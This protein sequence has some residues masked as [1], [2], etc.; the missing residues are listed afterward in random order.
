MNTFRNVTIDH[1]GK[2]MFV[3][4]NTFDPAGTEF[5]YYDNAVLP[6]TNAYFAS[7]KSLV[8]CGSITGDSTIKSAIADIIRD[9][10]KDV[11][12]DIVQS[13]A[14]SK[15]NFF[16]FQGTAIWAIKEVTSGSKTF[17]IVNGEAICLGPTKPSNIVRLTSAIESITIHVIFNGHTG[18]AYSFD[19]GENWIYLSLDK[20]SHPLFKLDMRVNLDHKP[21]ANLVPYIN[22]R[23][24][25][26]GYGMTP[27]YITPDI[28]KHSYTVA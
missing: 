2:L 5:I 27:Y 10:S 14:D 13:Y 23:V 11:K 6:T 22:T 24:L 20:T 17:R 28:T 7:A 12:W 18:L 9:N 21:L 1:T 26:P 8:S 4:H 15:F 25:I 3:G 19:D 16:T